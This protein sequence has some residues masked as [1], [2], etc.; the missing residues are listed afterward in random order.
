MKIL[1]L[2][3]F[4]R[5]YDNSKCCENF[6]A[7]SLEKLGHYVYRLQRE[8]WRDNLP[9]DQ[10]NFILISQFG[11]YGEKVIHRLRERYPNV[12]II[13]WAFDYHMSDLHQWHIDLATQSDIFFS[14]EM[15]HRAYYEKLGAHF[16]WLPED[17]APD[18]M[19]KDTINEAHQVYQVVF[20]GSYIT[21]AKERLSILKEIDEN[22]DLHIFAAFHED[23]AKAGFKNTHLPMYDEAYPKLMYQT[24][25]NI[26]ID[27]TISEGYWSDRIGKVLCSNGFLLQYYT[28]MMEAVFHDTIP[29]FRN[30]D[31]AIKLI[32]HYLDNPS[33]RT[34]IKEKQYEFG[35]KYLTT[36]ARVKDM[37]ILLADHGIEE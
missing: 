13:Y 19:D 4:W 35:Q 34:E 29:F 37:M 25:I 9:S 23:W 12:P 24:N 16:H 28:P 33:E 30:A 22:F 17:F 31:E 1:F 32:R 6:I 7:E 2:G 20:T 26:G 27:H 21:K 14:K 5:A 10:L 3:N 36:T 8:T 11:G 18:L 15:E